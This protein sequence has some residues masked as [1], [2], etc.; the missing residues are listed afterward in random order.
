[1]NFE[2]LNLINFLNVMA[3]HS[4]Y[5]FKP[6]SEIAEDSDVQSIVYDDSKPKIHSLNQTAYP[7]VSEYFLDEN[8]PIITG[9]LETSLKE[10]GLLVNV[11]E[12][13]RLL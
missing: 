12:L 4:K 10:Y 9:T 7:I 8:K 6:F 1:M 3:K 13:L 2:S 5:G 11:S